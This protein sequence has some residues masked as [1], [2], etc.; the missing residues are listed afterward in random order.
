MHAECC[1]VCFLLY[2]GAI[3]CNIHLMTLQIFM[4]KWDL[5]YNN[6]HIAIR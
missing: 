5:N 2:V 1:N 6:I 3:W 4:C